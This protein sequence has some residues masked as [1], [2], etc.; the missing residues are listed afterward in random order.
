MAGLFGGVRQAVQAYERDDL[1]ARVVRAETRHADS[2]FR[3]FLVGEFKTGKSSLIN[4]LLGAPVC[5]VDDDLATARPTVIRHAVDL[6]AYS[7]VPAAFEQAEP[8]RTAVDVSRLRGLVTEESETGAGFGWVEVGIPRALLANGMALVDTPGVGGIASVHQASTVAALPTAS[9]VV[10]VSDASSELT[11][12]EMKFLDIA[13]EICPNI[14]FAL[15]KIDFYPEWRRIAELNSGHLRRVG[16]EPTILPVSAPVRGFALTQNDADANVESGLPDLSRALRGLETQEAAVRGRLAAAELTGVLN[17][18]IGQV[19]GQIE[20]LSD[21]GR[22][23]QLQER[24]GSARARAE[25]FRSESSGWQQTMSDG[26][27]DLLARVD[28]DLRD[29]FRS[30]TRDAD[31]VIEHSDPQKSWSEFEPWLKERVMGD[32]AANYAA[33]YK[34]ARELADAVS[35]HFN[36]EADSIGALGRTANTAGLLASI[37]VNTGGGFDSA[38]TLATGTR[39]MAQGLTVI[40]GSYSGMLMFGMLANMAGL[41][42]LGPATVPLGLLL[43]AKAAKDERKRQLQVR[44]SEARQAHRKYTDEVMFQVAQDSRRA[45]RD[46][47]RSLRDH[48]TTKAQDLQVSIAASL[49]AAEEAAREDPERRQSRVASLSDDLAKLQTLKSAVAG[50]AA[51]GGTP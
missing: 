4:A 28:H 32:V 46:I 10:F 24:L 16:L 43:G 26:L 42:L 2:L 25:A 34:G 22:A 35:R 47:Q 21:P 20:I 39:V 9:V 33:L 49:R 36:A 23:V 5:P 40:R 27:T 12:T 3:V 37:T 41:A 51:G 48:F 45:S 1:L 15:T 14:L 8:T 18:L 44:R 50:V 7:V 30:I 38:G 19:E 17:E 13:R 11:A 31:E 29:R 6:E